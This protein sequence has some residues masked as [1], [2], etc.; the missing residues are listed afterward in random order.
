MQSTIDYNATLNQQNIVVTLKEFREV[1]GVVIE[2][3]GCLV[4]T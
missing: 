2:E 4:P 3:L 1:K